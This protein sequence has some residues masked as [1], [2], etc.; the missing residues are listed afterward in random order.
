MEELS[1]RKSVD[2]IL[3][4]E[5]LTGDILAESILT[6]DNLTEEILT[7][8]I[9]AEEMLA[10]EIL[11]VDGVLQKYVGELGP[12]QIRHAVLVA[13][14]WSLEALFTFIIIF[15]ERMPAWHCTAPS[16]VGKTLCQVD[17]EQ[18]RD[19]WQQ[20]AGQQENATWQW[21]EPTSVSVVSEW[22]LICGQQALLAW[23]DSGYFM[24]YCAGSCF[25]AFLSDGPLGRKRTLLLASLLA[26]LLT[27]LTALTPSPHSYALLRLLTGIATSGLGNTCYVLAAELIGPS[28][29]GP[30]SMLVN[31]SYP[32]GQMLLPAL[33]ALA[34]AV[35]PEEAE[36]VYWWWQKEAP[37]GRVGPV[38]A[39]GSAAVLHAPPARWDVAAPEA[40]AAPSWRR[41][42]LLAGGGVGGVYCALLL[43]PPLL[44]AVRPIMSQHV[45]KIMGFLARKDIP[46]ASRVGVGGAGIAGGDSYDSSHLFV[47]QSVE[48]QGENTAGVFEEEAQAVAQGGGRRGGCSTRV[49][50]EA[51]AALARWG[52]GESRAVTQAAEVVVRRH[53]AQGVVWKELRAVTWVCES[54]KWLL[55]RGGRGGAL[56]VLQG[57]AKGNGRVIPA[58]V[59]LVP[60]VWAAGNCSPGGCVA[61]CAASTAGAAGSTGG[62]AARGELRESPSPRAHLHRLSLGGDESAAG[63]GG[64]AGA[65]G[66][67]GRGGAGKGGGLQ[68]LLWSRV[69][70]QRLCLMVLLFLTS[71][72]LYNGL[73]LNTANLATALADQLAAAGS[74]GSSTTLTSS[75]SVTS[76]IAAATQMGEEVAATGE[77]AGE[78][79]VEAEESC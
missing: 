47:P 65:A 68:E 75:S 13:C 21:S 71:S 72:S 6:E 74:G 51:V 61:S 60:D 44:L 55:E 23:I 56:Q 52:G 26:S 53:K 14:A 35:G 19:M 76:S 54:P 64:T 1:Y 67:T 29:R 41:L 63:G 43:L 42:Y 2:E 58:G 30:A 79:A 50:T 3:T 10:E 49:E 39:A 8:E 69:H 34:S 48:A 70:L 5:V 4:D 25:F 73:T 32:F 46:A 45:A 59:V 33:A 40:S 18:Q 36:A 16:C 24:G 17:A 62:G 78:A 66:S 57:L 15:T 31:L 28:H 38:V 7:E 27:T 20:K 77:A 22:G 9:L 11:T 12:C 37:A